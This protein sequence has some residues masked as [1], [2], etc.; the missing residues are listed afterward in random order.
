MR[1]VHKTKRGFWFLSDYILYLSRN[2]NVGGLKI[3]YVNKETW[4]KFNVGD[5]FEIL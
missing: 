3:L 2:N 5:N 1:V 4:K